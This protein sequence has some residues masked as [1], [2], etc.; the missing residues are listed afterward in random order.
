MTDPTE[1]W[2]TE[3]EIEA[4]RRALWNT[5]SPE[6]KVEYI[7]NFNSL[8]LEARRKGPIPIKDEEPNGD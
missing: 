5:L 1:K 6:Q 7:E 4:Q 3:E 8:L 2:L